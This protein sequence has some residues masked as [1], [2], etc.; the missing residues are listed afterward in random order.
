M[1]F[2]EQAGCGI[3]GDRQDRHRRLSDRTARFSVSNIKTF[4]QTR[5]QCLVSVGKC[6]CEASRSRFACDGRRLLGEGSQHGAD[7]ASI[8]PLHLDNARQH[9]PHAQLPGVGCV[10]SGAQQRAGEPVMS[11][12]TKTSDDE[13]TNRFVFRRLGTY[14]WF[15][16]Y[17][18]DATKA[19]WPEWK[20]PEASIQVNKPRRVRIRRQQIIPQARFVDKLKGSGSW[21]NAAG[22][23]FDLKSPDLFS[24]DHAA[25]ARC[26]FEDYGFDA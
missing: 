23:P 24:S 25:G 14:K 10:N 5:R 17:T 26:R 6:K 2:I 15:G 4:C 7:Q 22:A 18:R 1:L 3:G 11:L 9:R 13:I 16:Q 19:K 20:F 12:D 21:L 8:L